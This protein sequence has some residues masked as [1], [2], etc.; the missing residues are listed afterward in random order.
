MVAEC[1]GFPYQN[2]ACMEPLNATAL[3]TPDKCEVWCGTQNGQAA[4]AAALEASGLPASKVEVYKIM[5]GG[6][7]C[8]R[9]SSRTALPSSS[10]PVRMPGTPILS[11]SSPVYGVAR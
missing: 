7:F 9:A 11:P 5:L 8:W 4:F 3:Y 10:S 6:G 1:H 2:H